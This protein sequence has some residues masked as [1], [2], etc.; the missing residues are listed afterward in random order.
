METKLSHFFC[1]I[2][3]STL[4]H[5]ITSHPNGNS[6]SG[7]LHDVVAISATVR[8]VRYEHE[9]NDK[10][11]S[12]L[13]GWKPFFHFS[14]Q[15]SVYKI[16]S[17]LSPFKCNLKWLYM[18]SEMRC[19]NV[20]LKLKWH[21]IAPWIKFRSKLL[22]ILA[23]NCFLIERAEKKIKSNCLA[24]KNHKL[25]SFSVRLGLWAVVFLSCIGLC[26]CLCFSWVTMTEYNSDFP[27]NRTHESD[28]AILHITIIIHGTH[29][30]QVIIKSN[31]IWLQILRSR[32]KKTTMRLTN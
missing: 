15:R 14:S 26:L 6:S 9:W 8:V 7:L 32:T 18:R 13:A 2:Y 17:N 22:V 29:E 12:L 23:R 24:Q 16:L 19:G 3:L 10:R 28:F 25:P 4:A 30:A 1:A 21:C 5:Q 31:Q 11:Y 20:H 27:S